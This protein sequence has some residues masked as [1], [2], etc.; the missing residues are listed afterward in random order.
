LPR[1]GSSST[2][3]ARKPL[4]GRAPSGPRT[5]RP[6]GREWYSFHFGVR[7][8][9]SPGFDPNA[10]YDRS[11]ADCYVLI[12]DLC[13][14]TAF[15]KATED[16]AAVRALMTDYYSTVRGIIH[17]HGGMLD[18][19]M[20]DAVLAIWGLHRTRPRQIAGIMKAAAG[21]VGAAKRLTD[22]WQ[23][24]IDQV[25]EPT[26]LRLGLSRGEIITLRR[27]HDHP[28]LTVL[29][30]PVNLA[31]RLQVAAEPDQLICTNT[32][33]HEIRRSGLPYRF[34]RY[35]V[36][37]GGSALQAKN[38]GLLRAWVHDFKKA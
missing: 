14:F 26:G 36:N 9:N 7:A 37:G 20:G 25:I 12:A 15:F 29:G 8:V 22:R 3:P 1:P 6:E 18:K 21:L 11:G 28:G 16:P 19:I 27:D 2:T 23:A 5:F 32:V 33:F 4:T 17:R 24:A 13:S 31:A 34:R 38:Y 30:N 35:D 10:L